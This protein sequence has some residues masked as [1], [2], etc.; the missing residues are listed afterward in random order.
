[1][2]MKNWANIIYSEVHGQ[3]WIKQLTVIQ[4]KTAASY[5][6]TKLQEQRAELAYQ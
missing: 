3:M 4:C 5:D 2:Y 6:I 1:M